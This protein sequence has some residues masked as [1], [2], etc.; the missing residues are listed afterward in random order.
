MKNIIA[1][2]LFAISIALL[3][4]CKKHH[5]PGPTPP[6]T[7]DSVVFGR[8]NPL[9][10]TIAPSGELFLLKNSGLYAYPTMF[11]PAGVYIT[12]TKLPDSLYNIARYVMDSFPPYLMAHLKDTAIGCPGCTGE[13][14][15]TLSVPTDT[16]IM[17]WQI[18]S[19]TSR[20]P[21]ELKQYIW[22]VGVIID[23]L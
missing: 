13:K 18:S 7:L 21:V 6:I 14:F 17:W 8:F 12:E 10:M 22:R 3:A 11:R 19:D 2:G 1:I 16:T 4:S 20:L 9:S 15:I 5:G 23:Q